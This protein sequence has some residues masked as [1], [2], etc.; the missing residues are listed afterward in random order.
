[1]RSYFFGIG[2]TP[3]QFKATRRTIFSCYK[4]TLT[5]SIRIKERDLTEARR[6]NCMFIRQNPTVSWRLE[7]AKVCMQ[8]QVRRT[9]GRRTDANDKN[10]DDCMKLSPSSIS[11]S[12]SAVKKFRTLCGTLSSLRCSQKPSPRPVNIQRKKV[13]ICLHAK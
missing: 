10:N 8:V 5:T 6:I 4:T 2:S 13:Y 9:Y 12:Y 3:D 11:N 7:G 1:M